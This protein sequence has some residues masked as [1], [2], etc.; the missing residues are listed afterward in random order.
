MNRRHH[1]VLLAAAFLAAC[2][3]SADFTTSENEALQ[4]QQ[5]QGRYV[6]VNYFAEWCAPCLKELPELNRF[7]LQHQDQV[8]LFGVSYD[9]LDNAALAELIAKYQIAFPLIRMQ[10][11]PQ[12]PFAK[13]EA[14]PAT[15][16]ITPQGEIKGPLMGEQSVES[17]RQATQLTP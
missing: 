9:N 6:V 11:A 12:L 10:P 14:L 4:W 2:Q 13:P 3:P 1:I 15:Y 8:S 7:Y 5:F 16:I 17:L